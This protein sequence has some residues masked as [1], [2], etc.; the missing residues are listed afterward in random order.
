VACTLVVV[1][2][3]VLAGTIG[4]AKAPVGSGQVSADTT[5]VHRANVACTSALGAVRIPGAQDVNASG[6]AVTPSPARVTAA[7]QA[8]GM[9]LAKLRSFPVTSTVRVQVQDWLD[10][11]TQFA[12][13][14]ARDAAYVAAHRSPDASQRAEEQTLAS[15]ARLDAAQADSFALDNSLGQ[16]TL[17]SGAATTVRSF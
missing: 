5:F 7:N 9:L 4:I 16:C 6:A 15:A 10:E 1:S 3:L 11:W 12:T 8:L 17:E 14:R 2:L 13:D